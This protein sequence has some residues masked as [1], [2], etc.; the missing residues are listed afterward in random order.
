MTLVNK[1][2]S[3]KVKLLIGALLFLTAVVVLVIS[4]TQSS[5]EFYLTVDELMAASEDYEGANL[6]ISGAVIGD[7]IHYD[8]DTGLL[9]FVIA[10][11]P[12]D[13]AL[14]GA[15]EGELTDILHQAV[16]DPTA[17]RM[18]VFYEG[19]PPDMLKDEAQAIL[20][21]QLQ[22]DGSF[23]AQELLLKCP[24]K[25]EEALPEQVEVDSP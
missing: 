20:T 8:Q 21:G 1:S 2:G 24:S 12:D 15:K 6:R 14:V 9:S 4:V 7:S 13:E 18:A 3:N 5:A 16:T 17:S 11:I 19:P 23:L 22:S 10:N 25:Y